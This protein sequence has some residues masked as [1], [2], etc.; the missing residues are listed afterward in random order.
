MLLQN[1]CH[2]K[3]ETDININVDVYIDMFPVS[4]SQ[5][6]L[7]GEESEGGG[8]EMQQFVMFTYLVTADGISVYIYCIH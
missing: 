2:V 6:P 3:G 5:I 8:G 1:P 4:I 7:Y